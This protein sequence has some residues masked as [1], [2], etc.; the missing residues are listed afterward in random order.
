MA[1]YIICDIDGCLVD[2][3]WL[4][5]II[6]QL[7][8][9]F[10]GVNTFEIFDKNANLSFCQ[11]DSMLVIYLNQLLERC[12]DDK[13]PVLLFMTARS[14]SI[15]EETTEF[16][17]SKTD[18][19]YFHVNFR[20]SGDMSSPSESKRKRLERLLECGYEIVLAIDDDSENLKMFEEYGIETL[21][22]KFGFIPQVLIEKP[23][24]IFRGV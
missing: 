13:K 22:W 5:T 2:T 6:N 19:K 20:E 7:K 24:T 10:D 4:W 23:S 18:L 9:R 8:N 15:K 11:V 17:L 21:Q 16:I 1:K 12:Y 3:S 14:E